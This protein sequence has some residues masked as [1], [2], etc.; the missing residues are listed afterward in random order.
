MS[1]AGCTS[2]RADLRE[3]KTAAEL[4]LG[5]R[6]ERSSPAATKVSA[7]EGRRCSRRGAAAPGSPGE[8][9]GGAEME[10]Y[11]LPA[12]PCAAPGKEGEEGRWV[13]DSFTWL[14]VLTALVCLQRATNCIHF[15][16]LRVF[17]PS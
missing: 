9:Y 15:P 10:R 2:G 3:G 16:M 1:D 11:G 5:E 7:G 6:R 14:L 13:E 4:Q 8:A 17:C 12:F